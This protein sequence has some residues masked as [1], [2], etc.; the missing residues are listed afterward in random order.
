MAKSRTTASVLM[1]LAVVAGCIADP[2]RVQGTRAATPDFPPAA[3]PAP[4]RESTSAIRITVKWPELPDRTHLAIP[5]TTKTIAIDA[6]SGSD[7]PISTVLVRPPYSA[8]STA[9]LERI[10][11]G[12]IRVAAVARNAAEEVLA[13]GA[14]VVALRPNEIA[15]AKVVL[16]SRLAQPQFTELIPQNGFP[17]SWAT[18]VGKG[19]GYSQGASYS[20]QIGGVIVPGASLSRP[21]D[22]L[23][24]FEV[25]RTATT[26]PVVLKVGDATATSSMSFITIA[27]VSLSPASVVLRPAERTKMTF[28]AR[29]SEGNPVVDPTVVWRLPYQ[30]CTGCP[31][32]DTA[33]IDPDGTLI[34][35]PD[36]YAGVALLTLGIN[37]VA[38]TTSIQVV[39][40]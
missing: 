20:V 36:I 5:L 11:P 38:A 35:E 13:T 19:F 14:S 9:F 16:E 30:A 29:D 34:G 12:T 23:V 7:K 3:R 31:D 15:Q 2:P 21:S 39:P 6:F 33:W 8:F 17:G 40:N 24:S 4:D 1:S 28:V 26:S 37:P 10:P 18:L 27:S 22:Q 25:P 32:G